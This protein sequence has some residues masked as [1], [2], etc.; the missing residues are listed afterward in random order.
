M[1]NGRAERMNWPGGTPEIIQNRKPL[2]PWGQRAEMVQPEPRVTKREGN[3]SGER[4][5]CL[6]PPPTQ[7]PR[8]L[9]PA[10][11]LSQ[12]PGRTAY[13]GQLP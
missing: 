7:S 11:Q 8:W 4:E 10:E 2:A 12:E 6:Y 3:H 13:K 9:S 1:D 5:E